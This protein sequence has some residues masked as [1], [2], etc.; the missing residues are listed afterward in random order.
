LTEPLILG[1][2]QNRVT[3]RCV[4][5]DVERHVITFKK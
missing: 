5:I 2:H 3:S 4:P 1:G